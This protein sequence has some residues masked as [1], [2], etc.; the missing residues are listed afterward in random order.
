MIFINIKKKYC[1]HSFCHIA[2]PYFRPYTED[3]ELWDPG[4]CQPATFLVFDSA[5]MVLINKLWFA[6]CVYILWPLTSASKQCKHDNIEKFLC[7]YVSV[8]PSHALYQWSTTFLKIPDLSLGERQ[9][10][11]MKVL[12]ENYMKCFP[13]FKMPRKHCNYPIKQAIAVLPQEFYI[14]G[15]HLILTFTISFQH[16]NKDMW[17][18]FHLYEEIILFRQERGKMQWADHMKCHW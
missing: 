5:K 2:Q 8:L 4:S 11:P 15:L 17:T 18:V 10:L 12:R 6:V 7:L 14:I 9:D 13:F 16:K 3:K 1:D